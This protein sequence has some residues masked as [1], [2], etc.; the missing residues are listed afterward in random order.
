MNKLDNMHIWKV[1]VHLATSLNFQTSADFFEEDVSTISRKIDSL[2]KALGQ[3]LFVRKRKPLLLTA[4]GEKA[5]D[6]IKKHLEEH[7]KII[8][9]LQNDNLDVSGEIRLSVAQG[10]SAMHILDFLLEFQSFYPQVTFKLAGHGAITDVQNNIA[11]IACITGELKNSDR[12][13]DMFFLP[14]S[15]ISYASIASPAYVEQH[16]LPL[17]PQDLANHTIFEYEGENRRSSRI[18]YKRNQAKEAFSNYF[19]QVS[20]IL[21][22]KRAVL[23]GKGLCLD[24]PS[25]LCTKELK[26]GRLLRILPE[27]NVPAQPSFIVMNQNLLSSRRFRIFAYWLK[28]KLDLLEN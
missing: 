26:E 15:S 17:E 21:T 3:K 25:P 11:D 24:M 4:A 20:D 6:R 16:G 13:S 8:A 7:Q 1:F 19:I 9:E 12:P 27:W 14:K 28:E 5:L 10:L 22:I 18:L 23:R 2:E